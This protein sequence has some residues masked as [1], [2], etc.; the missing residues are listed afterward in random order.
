MA[1]ARSFS[2]NRPIPFFRYDCYNQKAVPTRRIAA[3]GQPGKSFSPCRRTQ[4]AAEWLLRS[5]PRLSGDWDD[6]VCARDGCPDAGAVEF[7]WRPIPEGY[8][9]LFRGAVECRIPV[10]PDFLSEGAARAARSR[11]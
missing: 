9:S 3:R 6:I 2:L 11:G 8:G 10:H 4:S 1:E 7:R 5:V